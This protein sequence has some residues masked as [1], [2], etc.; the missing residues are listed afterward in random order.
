MRLDECSAYMSMCVWEMQREK[1][2]H[3][4]ERDLAKKRERETET[5]RDVYMNECLNACMYVCMSVYKIV[6]RKKKR[7]EALVNYIKNWGRSIL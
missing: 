1:E 6:F 2:V 4:M 7:N 5:E 3:Q